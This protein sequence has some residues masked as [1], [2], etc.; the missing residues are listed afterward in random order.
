MAENTVSEI[1]I[2]GRRP[3]DWP[4]TN[5]PVGAIAFEDGYFGLWVKTVDGV[6]QYERPVS[7]T[8][9][10]HPV[11]VLATG[12]KANETALLLAKVLAAIDAKLLQNISE[13]GQVTTSAGIVRGDD[14]RQNWQSLSVRVVDKIP[15]SSA[16]LAVVFEAGDPVIL[17]TPDIRLTYGD[18]TRFGGNGMNFAIL[19]ELSHMTGTAA[20][21]QNEQQ[22][23]YRNAT[24]DQTLSN[25][26]AIPENKYRVEQEH[27][28]N[29]IAISIGI[30]AGIPVPTTDIKYGW[31]TGD[32]GGYKG[33]PS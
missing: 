29:N 10:D 30:T 4:P 28:V 7:V 12:P 9:N 20:R 14:I 22:Y 19:H 23:Q 5:L 33:N 25:F 15:N 32:Y 16:E 17:V 1:I 21:V 11:K 27:Q 18:S 2:I 26:Y 3:D 31:R 6:N 13:L 8:P 24:G